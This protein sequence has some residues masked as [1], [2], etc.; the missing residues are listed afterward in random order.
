M[1]DEPDVPGFLRDLAT[2]YEHWTAAGSPPAGA[3]TTT[4]EASIEIEPPPGPVVH[5]VPAGG[6]GGMGCCGIGWADIKPGD[7]A[8]TTAE[9]VTCPGPA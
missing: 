6:I 9:R 2:A 1:T 3:V 7:D 4:V 5:R 8:T